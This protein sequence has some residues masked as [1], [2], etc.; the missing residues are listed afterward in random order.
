MMAAASSSASSS[1]GALAASQG[2]ALAAS[3]GPDFKVLSWNVGVP[4]EG[5][6]AGKAKAATE[7]FFRERFV[8]VVGQAG[9]T[10]LAVQE[11]SYHWWN[12]LSS[13]LHC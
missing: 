8:Q 11:I 6:N 3:Q 5:S 2:P 9:A 4:E 1:S 10:V 7:T 13:T 12:F